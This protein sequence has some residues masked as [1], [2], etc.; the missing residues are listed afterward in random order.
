MGTNYYWRHDICECCNRSNTLHIGKDSGGWTFSFQAHDYP[1]IR[2]YQMWLENLRADGI[3]EDEYGKEV[4][5]EDFMQMVER[6]RKEKHDHHTY[7]V[8]NYRNHRG[9]FHDH[10]GYSFSEDDFR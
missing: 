1:P 5:L 7:C 2:S 8:A 9:T 10:E 6:K 3:I 4:S